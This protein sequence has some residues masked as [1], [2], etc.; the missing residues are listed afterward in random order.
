M[1]IK[2]FIVLPY[3]ERENIVRNLQCSLTIEARYISL[4]EQ[5]KELLKDLEALQ[6]SCPH[7]FLQSKNRG[8]TGNYDSSH[9]RFWIEYRCPDCKK[10]WT[11][12]A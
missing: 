3:E 6:T 9:N 5:M 10:T 8:D 12:D 1:N 11:E 2:E 4:Q 7:T